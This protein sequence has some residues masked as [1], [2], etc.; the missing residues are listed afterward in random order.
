MSLIES[1]TNPPAVEF[2][3][4]CEKNAQ[5]VALH[6]SDDRIKEVHVSGLFGPLYSL[7]GSACLH[8]YASVPKALISGL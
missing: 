5:L 3:T 8:S 4:V 7:E 1:F 2:V 6:I